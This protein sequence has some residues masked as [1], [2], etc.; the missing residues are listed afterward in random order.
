LIVAPFPSTV[1]LSI[2]RF[3]G[4]LPTLDFTRYFFPAVKERVPP[5][6][7]LR[8]AN[9]LLIAPASSADPLPLAPNRSGVIRGR[10]AENP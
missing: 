7:A 1:T 5:P 4:P 9:A 10:E 3:V 8:N 6:A 2:N